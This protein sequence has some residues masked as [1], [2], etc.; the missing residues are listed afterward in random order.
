[1]YEETTRFGAAWEPLDRCAAVLRARTLRHGAELGAYDPV[2]A[3]AAVVAVEGWMSVMG[4]TSLAN[5]ARHGISA[6]AALAGAYTLLTGGR[7]GNLPR[8][9]SRGVPDD[10]LFATCEGLARR[11]QAWELDVVEVFELACSALIVGDEDPRI[12]S[13]VDVL[14]SCARA[15]QTTNW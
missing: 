14:E 9:E 4:E 10:L 2:A 15:S 1:M 12:A 6:V 13:L 5:P 7:F 11:V 8:S 3:A